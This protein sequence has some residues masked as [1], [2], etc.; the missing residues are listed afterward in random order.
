MRYRTIKTMG[1][2]SLCVIFLFLLRCSGNST[3]AGGVETTNGLTV[4][5]SGLTVHGS[6]PIGSV[7]SILPD[8]FN[9]I[10]GNR[11]AFF[12]S[13][14]INSGKAFSFIQIRDTGAYNVFAINSSTHQG[15]RVTA[16]HIAPGGYDSIYIPFDTL[17]EIS[18]YALQVIKSDTFA[19]GAH[20]V[21]LEGSNFF[22]RSDSAGHYKMSNIPW[23]KYRVR[24]TTS[25]SSAAPDKVV[26]IEQIAELND[27][28]IAVILNFVVK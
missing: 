5:A 16:L 18:G 12:D 23:G 27:Q 20:D 3:L 14:S 2:F 22:T 9:P 17:G 11:M 24:L 8:S 6:A 25:A 13:A 7:V 15:A 19:L 1:S 4:V 28:N 21:Y 10:S 26:K